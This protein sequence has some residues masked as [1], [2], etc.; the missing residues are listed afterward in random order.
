MIKI[1]TKLAVQFFVS[2]GATI[3]N[4]ILAIILSR[5]LSPSEIGIFSMSAV[6]VGFAQVFRD[7]GVSAYI[8]RQKELT[9]QVLRASIT[10]L[11]LSSFFFAS[12]LYGLSSYAA[13]FFNQSGV[14]STLEVLALGFLFI[15]FGAIPQAVLARELQVGK[16][17]IVT[18]VSTVTYFSASIILAINGYSYMSLAWANLANIIATGIVLNLLRPPG[19]P[20]LPGF[21]GCRS[22]TNFGIGAMLGTALKSIDDAIPD[23][24]LGKMSTAHNVGIF[25][26]A[27][28]TVN[29]LSYL[30]KPTIDYAALPYLANAHHRG[31]SVAE[32]II[33][34]TSILT[35]IFWP[36]LVF[37]A[38]YKN[39]IILLLYGPNWAECALAINYLCLCVGI[40]ITFALL[41]PALDGL[42]R[43]YWIALPLFLN[44]LI[45]VVTGILIFDGTL[46][47]FALAMVI[48][49]VVTIPVYFIIARQFVGITFAHWAFALLKSFVMLTIFSTFLIAA[50]QIFTLLPNYVVKL[51]MGSLA[52]L[53]IWVAVVILT[54]HPIKDEMVRFRKFIKFG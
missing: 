36:L 6:V 44:V 52:A 10:V 27:N 13:A 8:K 26:R 4:F 24:M 46:E 16:Q 35:G 5:I 49:E 39:E 45:K 51:V 23:I 21:K 2:F 50:Y 11:F 40:Q 47:S 28:S 43:P 34:P 41:R 30:T 33:R 48:S 7:F 15:P 18:L 3:A 42:G 9:N 20:W 1:R 29:I 22:V 12:V 37:I 31:L 32:E 19:L 54:S 17:A 14:G 25:S 53:L 38:L